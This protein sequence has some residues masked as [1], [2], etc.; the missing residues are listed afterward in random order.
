MFQKGF[1]LGLVNRPEKKIE[2]LS[3][4]LKKYPKS[5]Y[6]DDAVFEIGRAYGSMNSNN[7]AIE[8]F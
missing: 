7:K 4:L 5:S 6:T 3:E 8:A 2:T 1:A